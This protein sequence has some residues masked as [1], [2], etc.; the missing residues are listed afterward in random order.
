[1]ISEFDRRQTVCFTEEYL[2]VVTVPSSTPSFSFIFMCFRF[3][4]I[5]KVSHRNMYWMFKTNFK[6][7]LIGDKLSLSDDRHKGLSLKV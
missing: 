7:I 3:E 4:T 6:L 2:V 1:M 5:Y